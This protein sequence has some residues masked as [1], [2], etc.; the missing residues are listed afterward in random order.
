MRET[1]IKERFIEWDSSLSDELIQRIQYRTGRREFLKTLAAAPLLSLSPN[2][3]FAADQHNNG[4]WQREDPWL[5]LSVVHEHLFPADDDSP[6]AADIH[7]T[8][9]LKSVVELP[10]IDEE[11]KQFIKEGVG[12]L[13]G[14]SD[15]LYDKTFQQLTI[16]QKED[17]LRKVEQSKAGGNWLSLILLYLIEALLADPVYGGNPEQVGWRWLAHQPGYPL[18]PEHKRY[19]KL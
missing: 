8:A 6:G 14:L 1:K 16:E 9:Y 19:Y 15:D 13:N 17:V 7:A 2:Q 10:G 3:L 18:P 4:S 11:D 5:T 12:W